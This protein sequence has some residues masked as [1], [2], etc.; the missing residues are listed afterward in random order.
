MKETKDEVQRRRAIAW[1]IALTADTP[2]EPEQ[3]EYDLLEC[4]AQGTLTLD[5]VLS[6]LDN[7]VQHVLYRSR[8]TVLLTP[9][10]LND[11]LE[12]SRAWNKQHQI[13]GLLCY[14]T[15]GHFVQVLEGSAQHVQALFARIRQDPRHCEVI[16]L[17]DRA[18]EMRWFSDWQMA[19]SEL[20]SSDFF[21]LTS[22]LE[23]RGHNLVEPQIPI[24]DELLLHLLKEFRQQ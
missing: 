13:T 8:A 5:Q 6:K 16:A 18:T 9:G 12:E 24:R 22:Y 21:W 23:A 3:Y 10:Q 14:C 17:S 11:L 4:Y 2:L 19:F 15:S 1:A 20:S 7:R